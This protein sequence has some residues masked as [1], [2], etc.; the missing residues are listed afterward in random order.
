MSLVTGLAVGLGIVVL[1]AI[2]MLALA[3]HLRKREAREQQAQQI[4]RG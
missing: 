4:S 2:G 1:T 3:I